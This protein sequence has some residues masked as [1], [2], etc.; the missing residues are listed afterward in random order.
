MGHQVLVG[1]KSDMDESKRA[2]PYSK[3]Q[4]LADEFGIQFFETSAK[5]NVNVDEVR[6]QIRVDC[7]SLQRGGDW[8][9]CV[10]AMLAGIATVGG[11]DA[12]CV[13]RDRDD[14]HTRSDSHS[15]IHSQSLPYQYTHIYTHTEGEE[16]GRER[17]RARAS[18]IVGR[19]TPV[20]TGMCWV[21]GCACV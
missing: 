13:S 20:A 9:A 2:V 3:G 19:R 11:K 21:L 10:G 4:A 8:F 15:Y 18:V 14:R 16:G 12:L 17:E 7:C 5:N 6:P 1:N